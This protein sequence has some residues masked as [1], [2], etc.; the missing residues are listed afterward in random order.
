[1]FQAAQRYTFGLFLDRNSLN[2]LDTP[3]GH[4]MNAPQAKATLKKFSTHCHMG[5][6]A[7]VLMSLAACSNEPSEQEKKLTREIKLSVW[8][9]KSAKAA[10]GLEGHAAKKHSELAA[11]C[12]QAKGNKRVFSPE[13]FQKFCTEPLADK[14]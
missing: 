2:I 10:T 8:A 11:L 9:Y 4:L 12:E 5:I 1:M 3:K 6:S 7:I 14:S 13:D